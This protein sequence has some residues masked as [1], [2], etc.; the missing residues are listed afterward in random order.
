[1]VSITTLMKELGYPADDEG[2]CEGI[3]LMAERARALGKYNE[4]A[5][6]MDYLKSLNP[7]QLKALVDSAKAH[8]KSFRKEETNIPLTPQEEILL[9]VDS[10]FFQVWMCFKPNQSQ[11]FLDVTKDALPFPQG[12]GV[13]QAEELMYGEGKSSFNPPDKFLVCNRPFEDSLLPFLRQI[14]NSNVPLGLVLSSGG[15]AVHLFCEK[16]DDQVI[17]HLTNHDQLT[18]YTKEEMTGEFGLLA[19]IAK[20]F[21]SN[22]APLN[23]EARVFSS[24]EFSPEKTELLDSLR[25]RSNSS[26]NT[27]CNKRSGAGINDPDSDGNTLLHIATAA[28]D[29]HTVGILLKKP[30][31][32]VTLVNKNGNTP[33]AR[34]AMKGYTGIMEML[35][36]NGADVN[37]RGKDDMTPMNYAALTGYTNCVKLLMDYG[38]DV[39]IP[40]NQGFT[41]L[42]TAVC[43]GFNDIVELLLEHPQISVDMPARMDNQVLLGVA[44]KK[45]VQEQV[46]TLINGKSLEMTPLHVAVVTG[47][48][49][50]VKRLLAKGANPSIEA[51]EGVNAFTLALA[52][53]HGEIHDV[54]MEFEKSKTMT[55]EVV[56]TDQTEKMDQKVLTGLNSNSLFRHVELTNKRGPV[57]L[58]Q[59]S[60]GNELGSINEL[61]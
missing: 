56:Q 37:H 5:A 2:V 50:V 13:I 24:P 40:D 4:F 61:K 53:G 25:T 26:I 15:H 57:N 19:T 12:D 55:N 1:M 36:G 38:G 41:P 14:H 16:R 58:T 17:W 48:R 20:A 54:L 49:E 8:D 7:G 28:G 32:D 51:A 46:S 35:I 44:E 9:T 43:N 45:G 30:K 18:S 6:R 11:V 34:A 39:N 3:A 60:E 52:M 47:N 23:L 22:K 33:L 27:F 59:K 42:T 31:I 29:I 21:G 10:F